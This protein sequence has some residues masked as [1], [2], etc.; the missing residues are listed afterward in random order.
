MNNV[1]TTHMPV[2]V[3]GITADQQAVLAE[4][5]SDIK[6][7]I[8]RLARAAKRWVELPE[9]ARKR[10]VD[11]TNPSYRDFWGKLERVGRGELHPQLATVGGAAARFLGKLS[12]PEQERYLRELVPV[13]Q[14]KGRGWDVRQVDVAE[15]S[16][17][18]RKQVFK[19][20]SDGV[21]TVREVEA[22]KV[23]LADKAARD[24][25]ISSAA[26]TLRKVERQGWRVEKGRCY[27]KP[28]ASEKGFTKGQVEK[29]LKDMEE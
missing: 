26:E 4:I 8:D 28:A 1:I 10:I 16:E 3:T 2:E 27:P 24:L 29:M 12:L 22:Q 15:M 21:V 19:L 25:L 7:S 6:V 17:E 5:L 20:S 11:Q 9:K 13:V 14:V 23:W 18:Q